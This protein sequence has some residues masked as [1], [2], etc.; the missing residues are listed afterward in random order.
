MLLRQFVLHCKE[1]VIEDHDTV[2][3]QD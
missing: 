2:A 1:G 3:L